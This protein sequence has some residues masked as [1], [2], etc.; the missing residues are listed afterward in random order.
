M[1]STALFLLFT[2]LA[3]SILVV[4]PAPVDKPVNV[5]YFGYT[6]WFNSCITVSK[7]TGQANEE[8]VNEGGK[9][10]GLLIIVLYLITY[11]RQKVYPFL[12][13][14]PPRK[15]QK[16]Q[17]S[18]K[19]HQLPQSIQVPQLSPSLFRSIGSKRPL[20]QTEQTPD[21]QRP[22]KQRKIDA[23]NVSS[24]MFVLSIPNTYS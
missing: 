23:V 5:F 8:E 7:R 18:Q 9:C 21:D 14:T 15:P 22:P 10:F 19:S 2:L 4:F 24:F 16:S 1:R 6:H 13:P 11:Q 20:S 3:S 17:K 12:P